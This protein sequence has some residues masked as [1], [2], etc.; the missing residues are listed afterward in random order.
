MK[1]SIITHLKIFSLDVSGNAWF[2]SSDCRLR[3]GRELPV[4]LQLKLIIRGSC[5]FV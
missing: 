3:C 1:K 2:F 5:S 4:V